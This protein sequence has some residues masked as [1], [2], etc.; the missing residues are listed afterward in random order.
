MSTFYIFCFLRPAFGRSPWSIEIEIIIDH[1]TLFYVGQPNQSK[2]KWKT[3]IIEVEQI[4][5]QNNSRPPNGIW[6]NWMTIKT[7]DIQNGV[8][9]FSVKKI[10]RLASA[11]YCFVRNLK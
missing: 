2:I 7:E 6:P 4:E 11:W 8:Y 5:R 3:T 9:F 1:K 10:I